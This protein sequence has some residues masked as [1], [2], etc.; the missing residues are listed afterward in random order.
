MAKG[1]ST[2]GLLAGILV[3]G[4]FIWGQQMWRAKVPSSEIRRTRLF[5]LNPETLISLEF[6]C[7][8][9]VVECVKE[10]GIWMTGNAEHGMGRADVALMHKMLSELNAL[11]KGATITAEHLEMRGLDAAE[12]G[13]VDPAVEITAIDNK[14]RRRWLVGRKAPLGN[15]FYIKQAGE[16]DIH[17]V[18]EALLSLI[19]PQPD[20]LRDRTLFSGKV[21]GVRRVEIRGSEGFIQILKDVRSG[22]QIQQPF[23]AAA[24]PRAMQD[25][26]GRLYRLQ[27]DAFD[28]ENV[29]DF[30]AYGLQGEAR[31]ISLEGVDGTSCMLVI[32]DEI[33]DRKGFVYARWADE[34]SVFSLDA[35]V[36]DLVDIKRDTLRDAR[37]LPLP[38]REITY[39]SVARGSEQLELVSDESG[40]WAV[41]KPVMWDADRQA[42]F[43]LIRL[44]DSVVIT[45]FNVTNETLA[46]E[47][48]LLFGSDKLGQTNQVDVLPG[49]GRKDG[50]LIVREGAVFQV[51]LP[52][53]PETILDPLE[54]K[55]Q[56]IWTLQ[57]DEI[58]K[59]SVEKAA[60][61]RQVAERQAD[62]SFALGETNGA[63][64]LDDEALELLLEELATV[65]TSDYVTYNPSDLSIYGLADPAV[66]LHLGLSGTNQLGHVLL[67][68]EEAAQGFYAMVKGRDVVFLLDKTL[69]KMLSTNL[70]VGPEN[71]PSN[72]E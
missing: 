66:V 41:S 4:V 23:V 17:T 64:R 63:V 44:W 21:P 12:Y 15:M 16:G 27:I 10:N 29:S 28:A 39:I 18:P 30:S 19:P 72:I 68:G 65:S 25:L 46:A 51:N 7:S 11:G 5:L 37:M 61:S 26:L 43:E 71:V 42:V 50:L 32:G 14:G 2:L 36:L 13:L 56:Q 67:V 52:L 1:R 6:Q 53:V 69:A 22:W 57:K 60:Q 20:A 38:A 49:L 55:D 70:V 33:V 34:A 45:D 24:D 31:Q 35:K 3:L 8:N 62:G 54:Y 59:V 40:Q 9:T 48:T 58:Q 47:W